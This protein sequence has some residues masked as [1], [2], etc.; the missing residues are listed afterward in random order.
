ML[1][2]AIHIVSQSPKTSIMSVNDKSIPLPIYDGKEVNYLRWLAKMKGFATAKGIW[3]A[4]SEKGKLPQREDTPLDETKADEAL[5]NKVRTANG[6]LMAYLLNAFK[7]ASDEQLVMNTMTTEWPSGLAHEVISKLNDKYHP[8]DLQTD[9]DKDTKLQEV[10]MK[11]REDPDNLFE[12]LAAISAWYD[13]ATKKI[14]ES[15]KIAIVL[16]RSPEEYKSILSTEVTSKGNSLKLD[17]LQKVMKTYYRSKYGNSHSNNGSVETSEIVLVGMEG[18][19][20]HKCKKKGHIAK[21]CP[22]NRKG[23]GKGNGTGTTNKTD[24]V[25]SRCNKKGHEDKDCWDNPA[26]AGKRPKWYKPK[27]EITTVGVT[28]EKGPNIEF[29]VA[30]IDGL[31]PMDTETPIVRPWRPEEPPRDLDNW[32]SKEPREEHSRYDNELAEYIRKLRLY[33]T[34]HGLVEGEPAIFQQQDGVTYDKETPVDPSSCKEWK[35]T[36]KTHPDYWSARENYAK[37][38]QEFEEWDHADWHFF[39]QYKRNKEVTLMSMDSTED[40]DNFMFDEDYYCKNINRSS[41]LIEW[42]CNDLT[43]EEMDIEL[44]SREHNL[45]SMFEGKLNVDIVRDPNVFIVDTGAS[46]SSTGNS[47]HMRNLKHNQDSETTMGNGGTVKTKS[48]GDLKAIVC[49]NQGK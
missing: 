46:V 34:K 9:V 15:S 31:T 25:C 44:P 48:I 41:E 10:S 11:A 1:G 8:K 21:F 32:D 26:N 29:V 17:D 12:Q 40:Y 19:V 6:L 49:D 4:V 38:L 43:Y 20:C 24:T 33:Q 7:K 35:D 2:T 13:T 47:I 39:Q 27:G 37:A 18:V 3:M 45:V 22:L 42:E 30:S 5:S 16:A 36:D 28:E 23:N 14:A